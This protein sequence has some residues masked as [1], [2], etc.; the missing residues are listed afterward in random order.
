MTMFSYPWT[1][2]CPQTGPPTHY[3]YIYIHTTGPIIPT[4]IILIIMMQ[5]KQFLFL[6]IFYILI[7]RSGQ[8]P[9]HSKNNNNN[10]IQNILTTHQDSHVLHQ[11]YSI[12]L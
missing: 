4:I 1:T 8:E 5:S 9:C 12:H 6:Q 3:I 2:R 10:E 7:M 11:R